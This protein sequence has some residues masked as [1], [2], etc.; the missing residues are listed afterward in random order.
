MAI[1][2]NITLASLD[3]LSRHGML[4]RARERKIAAEHIERLAVKTPAIHA[5]VATLSGGNQQKVAL[6]RWLATKPRILILDEPT[7]GIDIGAKAD[8][9][10]LI[11]RLAAEGAA[12]LLISS[13]LPEVIGLS[14]RIAIM[15]E[16]R[17]VDVLGRAGTTPEA[18]MHAA[19][20]PATA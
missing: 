2:A 13:E 14:D 11:A 1:D 16:G 15:R 9:H 3:D 8:I 20:K 4:D 18:I 6:A 12:I 7:Q 19:L 5:P 10:G 17:V